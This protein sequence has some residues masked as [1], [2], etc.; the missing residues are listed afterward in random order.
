MHYHAWLLLL[1]FCRDE[2]TLYCPGLSRTPELKLSSCHGLLKHGL[3]DYFYF[4]ETGS[5][6]VAQSGLEPLASRDPPASASQNAEIMEMSHHAWPAFLLKNIM[7]V[8]RQ[9]LAL[10]PRLEYSGSI[11][12]DCKL[13]LFGS[14]NSPASASRELTSVQKRLKAFGDSGQV[15]GT[16]T[17]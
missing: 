12:A 10:L 4:L 6:Y 5:Y 13:H 3:P 16:S 2:V 7:S 8:Q 11:L 1:I 15:G 17:S 14:N 9:S